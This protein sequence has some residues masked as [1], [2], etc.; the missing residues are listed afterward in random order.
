M[1]IKP[2][3]GVPEDSAEAT[4]STNDGNPPGVQEDHQLSGRVYDRQ[5]VLHLLLPIYTMDSNHQ[6]TILRIGSYGP[7]EEADNN[8]MTRWDAFA[9]ST[10]SGAMWIVGPGG[11]PQPSQTSISSLHCMV[12]ARETGLSLLSYSCHARM[13]EAAGV[14][15]PQQM[16]LD[17]IRCLILQVLMLKRGRHIRTE[18][19]LSAPS[20]TVLIGR[21]AN[22]Q[23]A[24][25]MFLHVRFELAPSYLCVIEGAQYLQ[26]PA[27]L[28]HTEDLR[29]VFAELVKPPLLWTSSRS[30]PGATAAC[31]STVGGPVPPTK[32]YVASDGYV[33]VLRQLA[34]QGQ[35]EMVRKRR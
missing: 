29:Q 12:K 22:I 18:V 23:T 9:N 28:A 35:I 8:V 1:N 15:S 21:D 7:V 16:L 33:G 31:I 32:V 17:M 4:T 26:D 10:V 34:L 24:L 6:S 3:L 27:D 13:C 14:L 19:D 5:A 30:L 11:V 20:L 2:S 25:Q